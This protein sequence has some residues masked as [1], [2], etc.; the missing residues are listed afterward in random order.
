M[1][2]EFRT[3]MVEFLPRLRRFCIALT[4]DKD[5]GDDLVQ[6][7]CARALSRFDQW[8][9][10][11][12]VDSWMYRIAQNLWYDRMRTRKSRGEV[13][14]EDLAETMMGEDGRSV[15]ESRLELKEVLGAMKY[16][17][18][19]QRVLIAL[20]CVDGLSYKEAADITKV[21]IG[22]VMSRLARARRDLSE[23]LAKK[24]VMRQPDLAT[25][26]ART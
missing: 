6:E 24:P 10:S 1:T 25:P 3:R 20:V 8:D 5:Q 23:R 15:A 17:T 18:D 26:K 9:P 4:G 21:P 7:T 12:R 2:D 13:S 22:T 16:L 19:E 14:D 11:L